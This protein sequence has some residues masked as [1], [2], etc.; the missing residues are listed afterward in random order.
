M[1]GYVKA[2]KPDMK[3]RDYEAYKG[4]YCS[5][6]KQMGKSYGIF[7]RFTLSYDFV[8]LALLRLSTADDCGMR[9]EK[10]RCSF[11]PLVKCNKLC[12]SDSSLEYSA[13]VAMLL[14]YGKVKDNIKDESFFKRLFY[15]IL[16]PYASFKRKKAA[17][18]HTELSQEIDGFLALQTEYER[19]WGTS[20]DRCCHPSAAALAE[21]ASYGF[22]N[23]AQKR[24][25]SRVG[26]CIGKWV[27]LADA[28]DDFE[29]DRK[30]GRFN[31]LLSRYEGESFESVS[32]KA[33]AEMNVCISE[34]IAAFELLDIRNFRDILEN[35]L[36][37]GLPAE[38]EKI[39]EK[40]EKK[41]K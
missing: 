29:D 31:A 25:L 30:K 17:K 28:L 13:D 19:D 9:F 27:Y 20:L 38:Q 5:L 10:C 21:I 24:I 1:F 11:N 18:K 33:M 39:A 6:C 14:L 22:E 7:S 41:E 12:T 26:Y 37:K 15:R 36:Y 3:I 16:L 4:I 35:I 32:K 40:K 23:P 34:A 8:F 2:A